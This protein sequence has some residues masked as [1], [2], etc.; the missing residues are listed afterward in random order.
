MIGVWK[1]EG[2]GRERSSAAVWLP[3]IKQ[4]KEREREREGDS[5]LHCSLLLFYSAQTPA[6]PKIQ[7]D[8]SMARL[9]RQRQSFNKDDGDP[10]PLP[11][12]SFFSPKYAFARPDT[13]RAPAVAETL[14]LLEKPVR[15]YAD[16][17]YDLF[18]FGHAKSLEQAKKL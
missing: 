8:D 4:Q 10:R 13:P 7:F 16:G 2:K 5:V 12:E 6:V 1:E 3:A 17:I 18:H 15:V 14:Q 11:D 9:S